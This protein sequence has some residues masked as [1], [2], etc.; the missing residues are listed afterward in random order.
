MYKTFNR[1]MSHFSK[2][3]SQITTFLKLGLGSG[4]FG[5]RVILRGKLGFYDRS[6]VLE[7]WS[8]RSGTQP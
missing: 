8:W 1:I 2:S 6:K 3:I 7:N 4:F 5:I